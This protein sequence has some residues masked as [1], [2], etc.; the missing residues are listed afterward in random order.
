MI[1]KFF[2]LLMLLVLNCRLQFKEPHLMLRDYAVN[3]T[4]DAGDIFNIGAERNVYG[5]RTY[6]SLFPPLAYQDSVNGEGYGLVFGSFGSYKTGDSKNPV[7]LECKD[8]DKNEEDETFFGKNIFIQYALYYSNDSS[9]SDKRGKSIISYFSPAFRCKDLKAYYKGKS[10]EKYGHI[11]HRHFQIRK[12]PLL[13]FVFDLSAG[14]HYGIRLGINFDE[15]FDF[16]FGIV[17][18]DFKED[19]IG[20]QED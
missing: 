13:F 19:D 14:Y 8:P 11:K 5:I 15:L 3:R 1:R 6:I 9:I 7:K 4:R 12:E 20:W 17:G 2:F 18:I 16:L 10:L